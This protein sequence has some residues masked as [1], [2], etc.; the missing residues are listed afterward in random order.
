MVDETHENTDV[1]RMMLLVDNHLVAECRATAVSSGILVTTHINA[2]D[3]VTGEL[4]EICE[5]MSSAIML[6]LSQVG[7]GEENT[8]MSLHHDAPDNVDE[9]PF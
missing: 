7:D 1:F 9:I 4:R 8:W 2:S 3:N 5:T 6:M